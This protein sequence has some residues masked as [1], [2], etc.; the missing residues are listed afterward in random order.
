[1]TKFKWK[2]GNEKIEKINLSEKYL[3][4]IPKRNYKY[5]HDNEIYPSSSRYRREPFQW[6]SRVSSWS[7]NPFEQNDSDNKKT[8]D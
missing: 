6:L 1:M 2:N 3:T 5:I 4:F 8:I 7:I